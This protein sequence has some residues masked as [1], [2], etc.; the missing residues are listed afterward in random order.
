[1]NCMYAS[2]KGVF[3]RVRRDVGKLVSEM[4]L[5][6]DGGF[7]LTTTEETTASRGGDYQGSGERQH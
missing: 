4:I 1:M 3:Q 2:A 7:V 6:C 5:M